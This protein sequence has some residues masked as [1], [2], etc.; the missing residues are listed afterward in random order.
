MLHYRK[1]GQGKPLFVLHGVFGSSDNWQS[2]GKAVSDLFTVFLVDQRNHGRS[3][4]S[5]EFSY[6]SMTEDLREIIKHE[7]LEEIFLLGHSMGGKVAMQYACAYPEEIEKLIVVDIAP[8]EYPPHHQNIFNAFA[9]INLTQINS[10]KDAE[11]EL[12]HLVDDPAV[13]QF[14]LKNLDRKND[15]TFQ[16]KINIPGIED[17]IYNILTG[18]EEDLEFDKETLFIR[19][20]K[21]GY[22]EDHDLPLLN[23]HFP[24]HHLITIENA[25]HWVHAEKPG[26]LIDCIRKFL[27]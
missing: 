13:R 6:S 23:F 15:N 3:F 22:I 17:N 26:E 25:G 8:K 24:F 2:I 20:G 16:W 18:L 5:D 10:R 7:S 21:S 1:F 4:H 12:K 14:I 27:A 11:N 9:N 19:G